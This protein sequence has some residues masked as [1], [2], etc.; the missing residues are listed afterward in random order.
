VHAERVRGAGD[1]LALGVVQ[2][3]EELPDVHPRRVPTVHRY[4]PGVEVSERRF[5]ELVA[6]ALDGIPEALGRLMENVVVLVVD[7]PEEEGLLGLYDGVP[8]TERSESYGAYG[9]LPMP[10]RIEIYRLPI[11][12]I[13]AT[14]EEVVEQV[15]ITVVHEVA[16]HF[17]IDDDVLDDLGWG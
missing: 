10:D 16:H 15:G 6:D 5:E 11:C 8:L 2:P 1:R 7:E 13:C 9:Y 14:E 3:A 4:V 12:A 17:G